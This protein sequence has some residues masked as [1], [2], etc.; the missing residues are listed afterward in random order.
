[1]IHLKDK[2]RCCGCS[3]CLQMC[4]RKCISLYEDEE[5]FLYPQVDISFCIDC[6]L[7][8]EVCPELYQ[9]DIC[10]PLE[11][12]AAKN[13]NEDIRWQSSSGGVFTLLAEKIIS[14]GGVVFGAKFNERWEVFMIM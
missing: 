3:A 11:V 6:G 7:C 5:G 10:K 8:E 9:G 1:M 14:E 4:P 12:Y 13:P 2:K